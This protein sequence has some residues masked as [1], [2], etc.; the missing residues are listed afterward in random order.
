MKQFFAVVGVIILI[1]LTVFA[2]WQAGWWLSVHNAERTGQLINIQAKNI[3]ESLGYQASIV[4][5][6]NQ[7]FTN[8]ETVSA[9]IQAPDVS[10]SEV[11][12]LK[13]QRYADLSQ[14][15]AIAV[16]AIPGTLDSQQTGFIS[17]NCLNGA[18]S[19]SSPYSY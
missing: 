15:C 16:Q 4:A 11:S 14:L 10:G 3:Q 1:G 12:T 19:P 2:G 7:F 18:V 9:Q 6:V 17:A 5:Q 8:I 13:A